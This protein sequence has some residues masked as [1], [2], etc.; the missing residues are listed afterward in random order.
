MSSLLGKVP[1]WLSPRA[2]FVVFFV[3]SAGT[4]AYF[5]LGFVA[6]PARSAIFPRMILATSVLLCVLFIIYAV[7]R[8]LRPGARPAEKVLDLGFESDLE[9]EEVNLRANEAILLLC[10]LVA[11]TLLVGVHLSLPVFLF[12]YVRYV[13]RQTVLFSGVYSAVIS[14]GLV[15]GLDLL[16]QVRWP[17]PLLAW[18]LP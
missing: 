13:G 2:F 16:I 18:L 4:L 11:A 1:L 6:W 12:L 3:F 10:T 7:L 9:P 17:T 15:F 5:E 14:I 8:R